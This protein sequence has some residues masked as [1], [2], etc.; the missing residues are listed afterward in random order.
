MLQDECLDRVVIY[1]PDMMS[2]S[3]GGLIGRGKCAFEPD[4]KALSFAKQS[5]LAA[6][7]GPIWG[8]GVET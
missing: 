2:A 3:I 5:E 4:A 1:S 7:L 8:R 6:P